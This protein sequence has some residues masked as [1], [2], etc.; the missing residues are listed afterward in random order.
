MRAEALAHIRFHAR[1][2]WRLRDRPLEISRSSIAQRSEFGKLDVGLGAVAI[3]PSGIAVD[4]HWTGSR[5]PDSNGNRMRAEIGY[6]CFVLELNDR[7]RSCLDGLT[8][9]CTRL[10]VGIHEQCDHDAVV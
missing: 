10:E 9:D 4:K 2:A 6:Q 7:S 1:S 8:G 3:R 5:R